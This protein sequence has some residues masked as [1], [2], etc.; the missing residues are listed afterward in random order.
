MEGICVMGACIASDVPACKHT[1]RLQN[2]ASYQM[3][4]QL[5]LLLQH[6][7]SSN[8]VNEP[9]LKNVTP[10]LSKLT[11]FTK[12]AQYN[13]GSLMTIR[14]LILLVN[15]FVHRLA[16][17]TSQTGLFCAVDGHESLSCI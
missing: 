12:Q 16:E 11:L 8:F 7:K 17:V 6:L 14:W 1:E 15:G 9:Q 4:Q 10:C 5:D 2:A 3:P 13:P